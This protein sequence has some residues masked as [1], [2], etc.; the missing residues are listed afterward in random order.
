MFLA[1]MIRRW[2]DTTLGRLIL[3]EP[4]PEQELLPDR[5]E[6]QTLVGRVGRALAVM[7]PSGI[8]EIDNKH[9]DA[10]AE[11]TVEEGTWVQVVSVHDGRTLLVRPVSAEQAIKARRDQDPLA[12][13]VEEL[14]DPFEE[15]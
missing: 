6:Y 13:P 10:V 14:Q 7:L 12:T 11:S 2:P 4:A 8:V 1:F 3:V 9:Y 15:A 5:S